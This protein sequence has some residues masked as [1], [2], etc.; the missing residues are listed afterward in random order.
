MSELSQKEL[1][2]ITEV[3]HWALQTHF[4]DLV[5]ANFDKNELEEIR[6]L[7]SRVVL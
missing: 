7:L 1:M 3:A 2:S 6:E 5:N 4:D